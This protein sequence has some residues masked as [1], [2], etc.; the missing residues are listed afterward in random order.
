MSMVTSFFK[1]SCNK[2]L[3]YLNF[4]EENSQVAGSTCCMYIEHKFCF[5]KPEA[6]NTIYQP[7]AQSTTLALPTVSAA[8]ATASTL[9]QQYLESFLDINELKIFVDVYS[10]T[11]VKNLDL[12]LTKYAAGAMKEIKVKCATHCGTKLKG[13]PIGIFGEEPRHSAKRQRLL[14]LE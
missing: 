7:S 8:S 3:R 14:S 9:Q 4:L 11:G 13:G 10:V 12:K 1:K 2:F 6:S 5:L